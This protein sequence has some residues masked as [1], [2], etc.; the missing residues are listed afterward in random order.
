M[1]VKGGTIH[2]YAGTRGIRQ[3][4]PEQVVMDGQAVL[5]R[6]LHLG[7]EKEKRLHLYGFGQ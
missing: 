3:N 2:N 7:G 4:C 6:K 5:I 1:I